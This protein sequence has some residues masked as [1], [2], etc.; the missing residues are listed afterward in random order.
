MELW[1]KDFFRDEGSSK[2]IDLSVKVFFELREGVQCISVGT[3][4]EFKS[5]DVFKGAEVVGT[6]E[7]QVMHLNV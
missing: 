5:G 3:T 2:E 7:G 4:G 6:W 1:V